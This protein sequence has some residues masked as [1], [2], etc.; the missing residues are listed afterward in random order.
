MVGPFISKE[1]QLDCLHNLKIFLEKAVGGRLN[2]LENLLL[3]VGT[4]HM[5]QPSLL[6]TQTALRD[7]S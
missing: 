7:S 1:I 2:T 4:V 3:P 5:R 6:Q